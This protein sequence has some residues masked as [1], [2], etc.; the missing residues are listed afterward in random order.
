MGDSAQLSRALRG[1][2][3]V[4]T[5]IPRLGISQ[6]LAEQNLRLAQKTGDRLLLAEAHLALGF[7]LFFRGEIVSAQEHLKQGIASDSSPQGRSRAVL[8]GYDMRAP[9]WFVMACA[10]WMLGYPD[11]ALKWGEETLAFA[12]ELDHPYTSAVG[13]YWAATFHRLRRE[14]RATQRRAEDLIALCT[15]QGFMLFQAFGAILGGSVRDGQEREQGISQIRRGLA[16]HRATGG[17]L[18]QPFWLALLGECY[19]DI[20]NIEEALIVLDDALSVS[21]KTDERWYE[22]ELNR[23]K[24]E[25]LLMQNSSSGTEAEHCFR[26][27]IEIARKQKTKSLELR[28][29]TSLARLLTSQ[30]RR[31]EARAM[32]AE[33]YDWF[34]EGFD[35]ADLKDAKIL[36]DQLAN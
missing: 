6:E 23:L 31:D 33:I 8:Y 21:G 12:Q 5:E 2:W 28:A 20:G 36:L 13:L 4:N 22:A 14:K 3:A 34:T 7:T 27:A 18:R 25:L 10:L 35:T 17:A 32:L 9:C 24:G 29:A 1:L 11:Q 30:G 26:V 15:E 16:A 19:R